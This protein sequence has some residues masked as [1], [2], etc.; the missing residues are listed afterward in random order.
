M[1]EAWDRLITEMIRQMIREFLT[2]PA[3]LFT[4]RRL[5]HRITSDPD[6]LHAIAEQR[7][8]LFVITADDRSLKLFSQ[9]VER[10]VGEGVERTIAD[11][12]V[13]PSEQSSARG[14]RPCDHLVSEDEILSDLVHC[15]FNPDE[16]TRNCCWREICRVRS[17]NPGLVVA[18]TW[19]EI[20]RTR[21]YLQMRQN[22]RGF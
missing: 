9:A 8:D 7:P 4:F 15:S 17:A 3:E 18:E 2:H 5:A 13:L 14:H 10:I 22:P 21:G 20:C 1:S 16:L 11:V 19:R 12:R 6:V